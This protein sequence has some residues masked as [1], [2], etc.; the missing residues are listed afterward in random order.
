LAAAEDYREF[1]MN[2]RLIKRIEDLEKR[3]AEMRKAE[4]DIARHSILDLDRGDRDLLL[5]AFD[6]VRHGRTLTEQEETARKCYYARLKKR[7]ESRGIRP[8]G[9]LATTFDIRL[10]IQ[11]SIVTYCD[12]ELY[13]LTVAYERAVKEG[14][15]PAE[16]ESAA[17]EAFR[18]IVQRVCQRAG[19]PSWDA[20]VLE[21]GPIP[22][23]D[24]DN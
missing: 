14:R 15:A 16:E 6:A 20:V 1:G 19:F 3:A 4:P 5:T 2:K 8:P 17:H 11:M 13:D 21:F 10:A 9:D 7:Y 12:L 18:G 23:D 24:D 22:R